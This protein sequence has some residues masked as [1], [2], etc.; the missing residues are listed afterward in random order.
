MRDIVEPMRWKKLSDWGASRLRAEQWAPLHARVTA[1]D[2]EEVEA[3][4][5]E[6]TGF[7]EH[8][9]EDIGDTVITG[10]TDGQ[11][12]VSQRFSSD[13]WGRRTLELTFYAGGPVGE[14]EPDAFHRLA[15]AAGAF[16]DQLQAEGVQVQEIRWTELPYISRPF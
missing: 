12:A 3:V 13:A 11:L 1:D 6:L 9:R 5:D 8:F 10:V 4:V 15:K 14:A 16:V 2:L 7:M